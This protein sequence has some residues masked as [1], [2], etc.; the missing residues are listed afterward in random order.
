MH[1]GQFWQSLRRKARQSRRLVPGKP[2]VKM[3]EC[4]EDTALPVSFCFRVGMDG[5]HTPSMCI[6]GKIL[7]HITHSGSP[8]QRICDHKKPA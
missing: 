6:S 2:W 3:L 8:F 7:E 1:Y 5:A 4:L